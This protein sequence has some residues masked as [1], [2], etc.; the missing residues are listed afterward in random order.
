MMSW[1]FTLNKKINC[2]NMLIQPEYANKIKIR[3][4]ALDSYISEV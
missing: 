1:C 2:P 3:I 4:L